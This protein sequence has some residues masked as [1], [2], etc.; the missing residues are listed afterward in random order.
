L[1]AVR[2]QWERPEIR[3]KILKRTIIPQESWHHLTH[4][5]PVPVQVDTARSE[6]QIF[7][8][9]CS[10]NEHSVLAL[11]SHNATHDAYSLFIKVCGGL[12]KNK[13]LG[14][15]EQSRGVLETLFHA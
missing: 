8:I 14:M 6:F 3:S 7:L 9:I 1:A 15:M 13:N 2:F 4:I 12:I 5:N 10:D 11:S